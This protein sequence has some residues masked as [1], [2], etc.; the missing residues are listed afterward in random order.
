MFIGNK[1]MQCHLDAECNDFKSSTVKDIADK[2]VHT[3]Y[4][5]EEVYMLFKDNAL[6]KKISIDNQ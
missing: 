1:M 2:E 5:D 4:K 3:F 6:Y